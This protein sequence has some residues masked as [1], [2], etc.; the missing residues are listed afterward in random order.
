MMVCLLVANLGGIDPDP[1]SN[2]V[3][4]HL[5]ANWT[6]D[7]FYFN[8]ANF[9]L[10]SSAMTPR[11]Q[12]KI[13]KM[14]GWD[15]VPQYDYYIWLDSSFRIR[16]PDCVRWFVEQCAGYDIAVFNHNKRNSI[17]SEMMYMQNKMRQGDQY[18]VERYGSE[19]FETQV[20]R[21][22]LDPDFNDSSLYA[23]GAF[24][25]SK[26]LVSRADNA[27][28][29]WFHQTVTGSIQD[30]LSFPWVLSKY[31][32]RVKVLPLPIFDN[33]FIEYTFSH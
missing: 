32:A 30:Q 15:I 17:R 1:R 4:Q 9:P 21:Y 29:E 7:F 20:E 3:E 18:L 6:F 28:K 31:R 16:N 24:V 12:A 13:P 33:P 19:P 22:L 10:R 26:E 27:L 5:P 8:E 23:A 25:Y 11:L 14:L 2:Y